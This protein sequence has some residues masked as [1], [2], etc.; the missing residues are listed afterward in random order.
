M[1]DKILIKNRNRVISQCG[2]LLM[3]IHGVYERSGGHVIALEGRE[4][5]KDSNDFV[6]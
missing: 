3:V 4:G 1:A 2:C 6:Y 5:L